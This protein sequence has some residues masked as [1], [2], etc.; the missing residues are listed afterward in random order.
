MAAIGVDIACKYVCN[1][2]EC[3]IMQ[4]CNALLMTNADDKKPQ[5]KHQLKITT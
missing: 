1:E 5:K 2:V 3:H 4:G